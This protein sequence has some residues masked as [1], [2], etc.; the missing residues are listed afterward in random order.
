MNASRLRRPVAQGC[1]VSET[2]PT[3]QGP[4]RR[5]IQPRSH[6]P[7]LSNTYFSF[8]P[9]NWLTAASVVCAAVR[10]SL[11]SLSL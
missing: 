9:A 5:P 7:P 11:K 10:P 6:G 3:D 4:M 2:L 1:G 8:A